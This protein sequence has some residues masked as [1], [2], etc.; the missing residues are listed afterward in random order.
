MMTDEN[1]ASRTASILD[2]SRI[3]VLD[4]AKVLVSTSLWIRVYVYDI[5]PSSLKIIFRFIYLKIIDTYGDMLLLLFS[6]V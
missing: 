2:I 3:I 4:Y 6:H 1:T 5:Y